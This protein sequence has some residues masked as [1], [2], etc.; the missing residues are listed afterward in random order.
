M[1]LE[2]IWVSN[3]IFFVDSVESI[4]DLM[5]AV[6]AVMAVAVSRSFVRTFDF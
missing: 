2:P 6:F 3:V 4:P 1:A 5:D